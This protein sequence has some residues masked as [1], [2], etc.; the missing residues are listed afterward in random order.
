MRY[1]NGKV[2]YFR[3]MNDSLDAAEQ[4]IGHAIDLTKK[5]ATPGNEL[6]AV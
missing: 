5:P 3:C 1:R 4:Y 2:I 6:A